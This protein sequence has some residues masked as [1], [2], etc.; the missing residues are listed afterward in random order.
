MTPPGSGS[1]ATCSRPR[2]SA[3]P[4]RPGARTGHRIVAVE[5]GRGA[6]FE[7]TW[8]VVPMRGLATAKTRLGPDL[9]PASRRALAEAMLRRTLV[10]T[11]DARSILGTVVVT[12]DP[13]V[14]GLA[15]A[16]RAIGLVEHVPG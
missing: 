11:R 7:R 12:K 3:A 4:A 13:E 2:W 14:A 15:T 9:D 1:R 16:Y 10:A 8:A 5:T 6:G